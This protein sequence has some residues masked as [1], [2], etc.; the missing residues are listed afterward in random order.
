VIVMTQFESVRRGT[1]T[2]EM[3]RVATGEASTRVRRSFRSAQFS[4][5]VFPLPVATRHRRYAKAPAVVLALV[6]ACGCDR[7]QE[8]SA[9]PAP[10][11]SAPSVTATRGAG[12]FGLYLATEMEQPGHRAMHVEMPPTTVY[13]ADTP[14]LT[15]A[16]VSSATV[17][18]DEDG[19][20]RIMIRFIQAA[21]KK[22]AQT[23]HDHLKQ[24]LAIV[25]EGRALMAPRIEDEITD[26]V[27]MLTGAF[28]PKEFER[29]ATVI[30]A[31]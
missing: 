12:N 15:G 9:T 4:A 17:E 5:R 1:I 24:R 31:K 26:G 27:M 25:V 13:M 8:T 21:H 19:R 11:S 20:P 18:L 16:D 10:S 29:I 28:S 22:L 14:V 30:A 23:T 7:K 6:Y 2:P 3:V